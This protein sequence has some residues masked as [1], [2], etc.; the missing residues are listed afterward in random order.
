[1]GV[2]VLM[3]KMNDR[4]WHRADLPMVARGLRAG[5]LANLICAPFGAL[6]AAPSSANVGLC[7]VSRVGSRV[8]ALATG[9]LIGVTAFMP[10]ATSFLTALPEPVLGAIQV[11][12]AAYL[13]TCGMDIIC[14]RALDGRSGIMVGTS[15]V[16]GMTVLLVPSVRTLLPDS[17]GLLAESAMA[18]GGL[19]AVL[20]NLVFRL[21]SRSRFRQDLVTAPDTEG[22]RRVATLVETQCGHWG[23]RRDVARRASLSLQEAAEALTAR[24][25]APLALEGAFDEYNLSLSL[26]HGGP[27][28][29]IGAPAHPDPE[30]LLMGDDR[31]LDAA[32][33]HLPNRLIRSLADRVTATAQGDGTSRLDFHFEH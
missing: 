20:L 22:P 13:I 15:L 10:V 33:A 9:L 4:D 31:A 12:A 30:A 26:V 23:T 28:L 32:L 24:G 17:L 25:H 11:Y 7:H 18:S 8:V 2:V 21:G 16:V 14:D 6:P 3:D 5:G 19:V 1:M 27:P 29:A